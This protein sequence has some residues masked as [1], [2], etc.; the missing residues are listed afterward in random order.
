MS[1]EL[2][3][4]VFAV[5]EAR[6]ENDNKKL[7]HL[8]EKLKVKVKKNK[9]ILRK[10]TNEEHYDIFMI[11]GEEFYYLDNF[12]E[13]LK[14]FIRCLKIK[15]ANK[16]EGRCYYFIGSCYQE[17]DEYQ[18]AVDYL[19]KA[20]NFDLDNA[21][22]GD[23]Y[24]EL[25]NSYLNLEQYEKAL[26]SYKNVLKFIDFHKSVASKE[27]IEDSLYS[28]SIAYWKLGKDNKSMECHQKLLAI[29]RPTPHI[30]ASSYGIVAHR[31]YENKMWKEAI[32]NYQQAV[33]YSKPK[34]DQDDWKYYLN[35][36]K[37]QLQ[38]ESKK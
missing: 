30:L 15:S 11:L 32:K 22:K 18:K 38:G 37:R 16:D 2:M 19:N 31:F 24:W 9:N 8:I 28:M 5:R 17:K 14:Y 26:Q 23:L 20:L 33:K 12:D 29:S 4:I 3:D 35:Y 27:Y 13:A 1:K 25:G 21:Q 10:A 7:K 34:E 36:C 6:I